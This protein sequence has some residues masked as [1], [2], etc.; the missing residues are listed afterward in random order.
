MC[1]QAC[2]RLYKTGAMTAAEQ[3]YYFSPAD[4]QLLERIP[5]L[6]DAG[7]NSFKIEGRMKSANYVGAVVAAYR[8]VIDGLDGDREQRLREGL[9]IVRNDFARKKTLF[10]FDPPETGAI[11]W[12]NPAQDGGTGIKLGTILKVRGAGESK[13][14][15]IS[16][17]AVTPAPGDSVRFHRSD[18][19]DRKAHK[20]SAVESERE[21][22][23]ISLPDGFN[24]GDSVYLIQ[25]KSMSRRYAPVTPQRLDAFRRMPG[26]D[27]AP[28]ITLPSVK[29]SRNKRDA[30]FPE[31]FYGA[32]SRIED[33][34]V[35]QSVRPVKVL[36]AYSRKTAAYL[37]GE[38]KPPLPFT[39]GE[40]ILTL[41]P[42]FP[43]SME[44]VLADELPRLRE[45]GYRQFV[46]N[47]PGHYACF[48][49]TGQAEGRRPVSLIA[50]PY[51]YTFNRYA[52]AFVS[53]LGTDT[54]ITPLENNRQ[55]LERTV[56]QDRRSLAFVTV[57]AWPALFRI[58]ADLSGVYDFS[59]FQDNRGEQFRLVH[60]G[61]GSGG[62]DGSIVIPEKPFSIVDKIPF[63]MEAGFSRF[64]FD[65][66]G[67][68]LKKKD[69]KD[70]MAAAKSGTPLPDLDRFNWK[71]GFF[72]AEDKQQ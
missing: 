53:S 20:I 67:P 10:Y 45:L 31:G 5:D 36:L 35:V 19:S 26:R 40:I 43:Q 24:E 54:I 59:E 63:L 34:Y 47:N 69:Y 68:V 27:K 1:T 25:T 7:V 48:R 23:W 46:V 56:P 37:L 65:F 44:A 17:G 11:D 38:D 66:S 13:R 29:P 55:N 6:A 41:D 60:R 62:S 9:D 12:L 28:V 2:R 72:S 52:A 49:D 64:I 8:R 50:G 22:V 39:P 57:F 70:I 30:P 58:R 32:V 42:W 14:A 21:G 71:D 51:L 61:G 4:L 33:L 18:D 16:G 3:G 15:L